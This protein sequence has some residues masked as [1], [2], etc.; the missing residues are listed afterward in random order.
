MKNKIL[1]AIALVS[2]NFAAVAQEVTIAS[3]AEEISRTAVAN[4]KLSAEFFKEINRYMEGTSNDRTQ[5]IKLLTIIELVLPE[6]E[7]VGL[8][9]EQEMSTDE[10]LGEIM[11]LYINEYRHPL[12]HA[13]S[14]VKAFLLNPNATDAQV[15]KM[16]KNLPELMLVETLLFQLF[17]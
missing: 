10:D 4:I 7:K 2:C 11:S 1:L 3:S 8:E 14:Y 6:A 5:L 17:Q 12:L 9:L 13:V 15:R 16:L